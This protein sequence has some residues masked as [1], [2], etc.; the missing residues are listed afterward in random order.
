MSRVTNE[1]E[2]TGSRW[3]VE[4]AER[5]LA[6]AEE[7]RKRKVDAEQS[8]LQAREQIAA[9]LLPA[10]TPGGSERRRRD[11]LA[12]SYKFDQGME[13][14]LQQLQDDKKIFDQVYGGRGQAMVEMYRR[15]K[16][17]AAEAESQD[18]DGAA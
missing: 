14:M 17:A 16:V 1:T 13:N 11:A 9:N 18:A 3:A 7:G 6:D 5:A 15:A 10:Y 12:A 4:Q 2:P 8:L